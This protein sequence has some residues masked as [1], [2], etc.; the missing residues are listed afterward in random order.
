MSLE[1][2]I[3]LQTN[4]VSALKT[5]FFLYFLSRSMERDSRRRTAEGKFIR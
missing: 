3:S 1:T 5:N 2:Y 4:R